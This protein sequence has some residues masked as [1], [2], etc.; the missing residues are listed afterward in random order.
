MAPCKN[1]FKSQNEDTCPL[2][3]SHQD[4][5]N[6]VF[7]CPVIQKEIEPNE[8]ISNIYSKNISIKLVQTLT[9]ILEIRTHCLY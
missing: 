2:C 4:D 8:E 5:Q 9:K 1:N 6:L 3:N 7:K